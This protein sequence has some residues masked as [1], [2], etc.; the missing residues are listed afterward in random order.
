MIYWEPGDSIEVACTLYRNPND[1]WIGII[2]E[3]YAA[4]PDEPIN[5]EEDAKEMIENDW[6]PSSQITL[7][8]LV[9]FI[10][11]NKDEFDFS[12]NK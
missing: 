7:E 2:G 3:W 11:D 9:E 4:A 8:E 10:K 6:V 5:P 1:A 12:K